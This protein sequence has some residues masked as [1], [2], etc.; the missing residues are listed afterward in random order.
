[1]P[2]PWKTVGALLG[3]E[4]ASSPGARIRVRLHRF[5]FSGSGNRIDP[6]G[7]KRVATQDSSKGKKTA[8]EQPVSGNRLVG[9]G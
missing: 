4:N 8:F 3:A 1:V 9:V 2:E 6:S 5:P 7:V